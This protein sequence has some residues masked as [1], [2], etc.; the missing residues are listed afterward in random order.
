[1]VN[2]DMTAREL[3]RGFIDENGKD[4]W[5]IQDVLEFHP[6]KGYKVTWVGWPEPTCML[7]I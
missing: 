6:I 1:V 2:D 4:V 5:I 3:A 7:L